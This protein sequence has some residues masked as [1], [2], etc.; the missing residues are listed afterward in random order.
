VI[1]NQLD[2]GGTNPF[3]RTR[4]RFRD[5]SDTFQSML[6]HPQKM[7]DWATWD[8]TVD[9]AVSDENLKAMPSQTA[10]PQVLLALAFLARAGSPALRQIAEQAVNARPEFTPIVSV[11]AGPVR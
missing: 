2:F 6:T 1:S 3:S 4:S 7:P 8:E 11:L 10:D 9:Q 5:N